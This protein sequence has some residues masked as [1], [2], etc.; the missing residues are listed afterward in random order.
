MPRARVSAVQI[1][2]RLADVSY[3]VGQ[4]GDLV[5]GALK[6]GA[7]YVALP[8]FFTTPIV[9][10]ERLFG[11]SLAPENPAVDMLRSLSVGYEAYVGGS[12]LEKD[13]EDVYNTYVLATPDGATHRHRKDIPTMIENAYYVGGDD[14]GIASADGHDIGM[15]VCWETIRKQTV[16]RLRERVDVL[17]TGSHWWSVPQ[18]WLPKRFWDRQVRLNA[19]HM[20]RAP[21]RL[22]RLVGAPSLHAAH[23]GILEGE[24]A[25]VRDVRRPLRTHLCGE[26]QVCDATGA[27]LARRA[28]EEGPGVVSATIAIGRVAPTERPRRGYW[29]ENL[30]GTVRFF[31]RHQNAVGRQI[32]EKAKS[33]N[34]L[35][36]LSNE[37]ARPSVR[38]GGWRGADGAHDGL[39]SADDG[40]SMLGE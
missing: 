36:C 11:C 32:Y 29:L 16:E 21:G 38:G 1:D 18:G 40:A 5:E 15:A 14:D 13:G 12:F 6:A 24:F 37:E 26:T 17:M 22:A 34:K 7:E 30:P 31:W 35:R 10:D 28:H 27:V 8:E 2:G 19:D 25:P 39:Q 23:C 9:L 20:R 3:N 4:C 33:E